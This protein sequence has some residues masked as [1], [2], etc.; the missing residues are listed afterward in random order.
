MKFSFNWLKKY[1]DTKLTITQIAERLT[2][3]GLEVEN[4]V[5]PAEIFKNFCLVQIQSAEKHP[6]ADKL[7]VCKVIDSQQNEFQ[8][9]CGAK[10]ARVGLKT[11]LARPG[12]V[13][14]ASGD[15]LKKNKLRGVVSEGMMCS[16]QELALPSHEDGIIELPEDM[17]LSVAVGD[18][19]NCGGGCIDV[20]VTPNRG[21]C[22]SVKGIARDL[23]AAGSGNFIESKIVENQSSFK[24]PIQINYMQND[25]CK[26]YAPTV[27]F[28]MIR[29]VKNAETPDW[30]KADLQSAGVNSISLIVDLANWVM[31]D[32]GRP[33]HMYDADKIEGELS[34]RF[35]KP[36]EEFIDI[37]DKPYELR[38][39]MLVSAD[40]KGPL[41]LLGVMGGK[42]VACSE[43][44]KNILVESGI[45][46]PIFISKTG[47]FLNILSDS[48]TRFERG[49]D[50]K[51]SIPG[52]EC[53][54]KLILDNCGGE[55]S[56]I[57]VVGS[58]KAYSKQT[59]TL[60]RQKLNSISGYDIDWN[61]ARD[62]LKKLGM[63]EVSFT[64]SEVTVTIP[65]WRNDL[66]IEEDL[67]EEILRINGYD[68]VSEVKFD[69]TVAAD[70]EKLAALKRNLGVVHL[71]ASGGLSE[72]IS[73][74]FIKS[75]I[76]EEFKE[77]KKLIYLINPISSDMN[78]LRPSIIP[79]LLLAALRSLNYG[80]EKIA[81]CE[82]GH[83]FCD[84]CKQET[85][86][87]GLRAG[88]AS[89]RNWLQPARAV[90][91]FDAKGDMLLA[92][93]GYGIKEQNI[94]IE[95][96]A[97]EYY[98]PSRSG[99][100]LYRKKKIGHFGE[101]HP[102]I[103]KLLGI[104]ERVVCFE[105]NVS[106]L[107]ANEKR[108]SYQDKV[109]PRINRDFAF[110][111]NANMAI[112]HVISGVRKLDN[113]ISAVDVFDCFEIGSDKKSIGIGVTLEAAD[114]TLTDAEAQEV[115]DKILEYV[116]NI[117]GELRTK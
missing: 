43:E 117:G 39:D 59:V 114:R 112:G 66:S 49:I 86:I 27:A 64:D 76:A 52:I 12:A 41:C 110:L 7:K 13:I 63:T 58:N 78:V 30:L 62:I 19:L 71:L 83:V 40:E 113:R 97:P 98:H 14:P 21:D 17:D 31:I 36:K 45:F 115:S 96:T 70:N 42:R 75:A 109:F 61:V 53:I 10:N 3:I 93:S 82:L 65:S 57:V 9:V 104:N 35:A 91:V 20:S 85:N 116:T 25:A 16:F 87:A 50:K 55:A 111:F 69:E 100:V 22:F 56:D 95:P 11:V 92:L 99:T 81:I 1:L 79:S 26:Q 46:D 4:V 38:Q 32:S 44:T 48:R 90:D 80:Q 105:L 72:V 73:Y 18:A 84:N 33:L 47:S 89:D 28:R 29:N 106:G 88:N 67:V 101:L 94:V 23:A 103:N 54:T 6:D 68:K 5:D 102:K 107:E 24:F 77:D 51:S 34:V 2:S 108:S 8:I 74:S 60:T 15:V 37:K